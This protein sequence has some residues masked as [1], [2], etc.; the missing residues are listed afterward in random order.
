[1]LGGVLVVVAVG[2]WGMSLD[3]LC[4][5]ALAYCGAVAVSLDDLRVCQPKGEG[6]P[7]NERS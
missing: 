5:C 1:M 6:E 3:D 7:T 2:R 4:V